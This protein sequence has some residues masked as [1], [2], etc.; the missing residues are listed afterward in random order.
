M[1]FGALRRAAVEALNAGARD[2]RLPAQHRR[3]RAERRTTARAATWCSRSGTAYFGCRDADG[4]FSLPRLVELVQRDPVRAIE[5]KLSQGAKPGVGGLLPAAKVTAEIAAA[6]GVPVRARL[7]Q[8]ARHAAFADVDGDARV[9]RDAGRRHR[10]AGGHQVGRRRAAPSG[11]SSPR[12]WPRPAAGVDFVTIDGGEGGTGAAPLV[13]ADHV[14]LPFRLG[15][16]AGVPRVRRCGASTT[17]VV[18]IGSGQ[19]RPA[20]DGA[21]GA[22]RWAATW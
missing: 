22:S 8:P 19:A 20:R 3:G 2:R 1:S 10:P 17:D 11:R 14:A 4:R 13:F 18:F 7:R 16:G 21:P 9:R 6:R 12:A 5:I 15:M